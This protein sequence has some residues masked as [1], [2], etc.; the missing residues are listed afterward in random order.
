MPSLTTL[1]K[2]IVF[3]HTHR[4]TLKLK[5]AELRPLYLRHLLLTEV[6]RL[7]ELSLFI[8]ELVFCV[9]KR[10][11]YAE[12][13]KLREAL[14]PPFNQRAYELLSKLEDRHV[15]PITLFMRAQASQLFTAMPNPEARLE[16][17]KKRLRLVLSLLQERKESSLSVAEKYCLAGTMEVIGGQELG[18]GIPVFYRKIQALYEECTKHDFKP[19][20]CALGNYWWYLRQND[21]KAV[22]YYEQGGKLGSPL[23]L[24]RLGCLYDRKQKTDLCKALWEK[25]ATLGHVESQLKLFAWEID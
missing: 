21:E 8:L 12:Y 19:A 18:L 11:A 2:K 1:N 23:C 9:K 17:R 10:I 15:S 5:P 22:F 14:S 4:M 3:I 20:F 7:P 6:L 24:Y 16:K 13:E 25:A